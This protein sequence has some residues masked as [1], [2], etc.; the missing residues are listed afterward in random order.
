[1]AVNPGLTTTDRMED[2]IEV[3]ST[4]AG[5]TNDVFRAAL[6]DDMVPL[7]RFTAPEEVAEAI[8]YLCSDAA[9]ATTGSAIQLDGAATRGVF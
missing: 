5:M 3:W 4:D 9:A 8:A 7:G 2:A 6:V 1:M